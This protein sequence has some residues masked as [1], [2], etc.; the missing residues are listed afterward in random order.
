M[1]FSYGLCHPTGLL[2]P[3]LWTSDTYG[4][5]GTPRF[6]RP[7]FDIQSLSPFS[8]GIIPSHHISSGLVVLIAGPWHVSTRPIPSLFRLIKMSNIEANLSS[9]LAAV[10]YS[11]IVVQSSVWYSSGTVSPIE[12]PGPSRFIWDSG[13]FAQNIETRVSGFTRVFV[14]DQWESLPEKLLLYDYIGTN[15]AK[16]GLFRS[17]PMLRGEGIG[18]SFL[19]HPSFE[20]GSIAVSVRRMPAFFEGFPVILI[21]QGGRLRADIPFRRA[22]SKFSIEETEVQTIF[23][24]G[25]LSG[26]LVKS[27]SVVKNFARKAVSGEIFSFTKTLG[28]GFYADGVPRSSC[29]GWFSFSHLSLGIT[30]FLGHL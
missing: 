24:G 20:I 1:C 13:F 4:L 25:E 26:S 3:G 28:Q 11:S 22:E 29:R 16:G 2:G 10:F 6:V 18:S 17:G 5:L 19:G 27:P 21:D 9:S 8:Y 15:P 23:F 30:S 14:S 7:E 12:L